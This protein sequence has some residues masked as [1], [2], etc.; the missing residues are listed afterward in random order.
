MGGIEKCRRV[1]RRFLFCSLTIREA[2]ITS[3]CGDVETPLR[4]N[5]ILASTRNRQF[6][7]FELCRIGDHQTFRVHNPVAQASGQ[8]HFFEGF[9]PGSERTLA[10]W[11]RHASRTN[12]GSNIGGSGERGSKAW[13]TYLRD[14]YSHS[15][16]W[17]IPGDSVEGHLL[18]GKGVTP[19]EGFTCY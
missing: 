6:E 2:P 8:G 10:A 18:T 9:D 12:P 3:Q 17:V 1:S 11:I 19:G 13:I 14:G 4:H 15:N 5:T 16:E 7:S